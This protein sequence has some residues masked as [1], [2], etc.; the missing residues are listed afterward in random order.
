[1]SARIAWLF[2]LGALL[3]ACTGEA[4]PPATTATPESQVTII[5]NTSAAIFAT[6]TDQPATPTLGAASLPSPTPTTSGAAAACPPYVD[7]AF[8]NVR[9]TCDATQ[10]NQVCYSNN[11]IEASLREGAAPT[12]FDSP[13]DIAPITNF[14]RLSLL[15]DL[16]ANTWG[17][18]LMRLQANLPDT[19]PGENVTLLLFGN[20][21]FNDGGVEGYTFTSGIGTVTCNGAPADGLLVQT[22]AGA[23]EI[24]MRINGADIRLG[25][26][27][28]LQ[29]QPGERMV[30]NVVE[31]RAVVSARGGTEVVVAG[32]RT[33]IRLDESGTVSSPPAPPEPYTQD[34]VTTLPVEALDRPIEVPPPLRPPASAQAGTVRAVDA[35]GDLVRTLVLA[36]P[37]G[38]ANPVAG[39]ATG[40]LRLPPG[41]YEIAVGA[42]ATLRAIVTVEA[43]TQTTLLAATGRVVTVDANGGPVMQMLYAYDAQDRYVTASSTGELRLPPGNYTIEVMTSPVR[44]EQISLKA[45]QTISI[46]LDEMGTIRLVSADG[47]TSTRTTGLIYQGENV[48]GAFRD[49]TA[50]VLPGE[51]RLSIQTNPFIETT[52]RVVAGQ[53]TVIQ[54]PSDGIIQVIDP[55]GKPLNVLFLARNEAGEAISGQGSATVRA[56]TYTVELF[57]TPQ[58]QQR[59][60]VSGADTQTITIQRPGTVQLVDAR[61]VAS[62]TFM[63][64]RAPDGTFITGVSGT[65]TLQPGSYLLEIGTNP[66]TTTRVSVVSDQTATVTLTEPGLLTL[67]DEGGKPISLLTFV[68]DLEG[69]SV[70]SSTTMPITLNPGEYRVEVATTPR[71]SER[72]RIVAGQTARVAVPTPGKIQVA[73][74][75]GKLLDVWYTVADLQGQNITGG[76]GVV[77]IQ[78][79]SYRVEVSTVPPTV[80][81]V[82]V[83]GARTTTVTVPASGSVQIVDPQGRQMR[84]SVIVTTADGRYVTSDNTGTITLQPGD[85]RFDVTLDG[86]TISLKGTIQSG[87]VTNLTFR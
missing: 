1:M 18:A 14:T 30:V 48:V 80:Q 84:A 8:K 54:L 56:G 58:I 7:A 28:F 3:A 71:I 75:A 35:N 69:R 52:A 39:S 9:M 16:N 78:P 26:T 87:Q 15:A 72:V 60:V 55:E 53:E 61:G 11:R 46:N 22:P 37:Q 83:V 77:E 62:D 51:Y 43:N 49:G 44:R 59:V 66:P 24:T 27:A 23:Y 85:Y 68:Y 21:T 65:A 31:G 10:R 6:A 82:R 2:A 70:T 81:E 45:D 38:A 5:S 86:R 42:P 33:Q 20:A 50:E 19:M 12:S 64:V 73:D 29:A 36:Y 74:S 34:T 32:S 57:T 47:S 4:A 79:G 13:G 63:T 25:S 40:E 41:T 76:T 67:V 17:I